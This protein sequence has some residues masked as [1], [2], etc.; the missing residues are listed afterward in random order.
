MNDNNFLELRPNYFVSFVILGILS[1]QVLILIL[2]KFVGIKRLLPKFLH[3][4]SYN[5]ERMIKEEGS[6]AEQNYVNYKTI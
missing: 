2:Q 5:Y 4:E 3:R 6:S 1:L